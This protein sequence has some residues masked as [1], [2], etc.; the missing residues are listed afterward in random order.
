VT[1]TAVKPPREIDLQRD[2]ERISLAEVTP[3]DSGARQ[4]DRLRLIWERRKF[5]M[6]AGT[7]ALVASTVAALLIPKFEFVLG[8]TGW[9]G[10]RPRRVS[11]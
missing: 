9:A 3:D 2:A 6:R 10:Q 1:Q 11:T 5:F 7:V 4:V 8:L